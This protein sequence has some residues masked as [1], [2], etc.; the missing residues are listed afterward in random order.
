[1]PADLLFSDIEIRTLQA[2]AEKKRLNVPTTIGEAVQLV[3][4]MGGY[5]SQNNAPPP[6]HQVL[7]EQ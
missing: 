2:Y 4:N 5:I 1:M 6:G 7:P 3:A